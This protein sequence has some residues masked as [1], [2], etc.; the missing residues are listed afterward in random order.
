MSVRSSGCG[1]SI[2]NTGISFDVTAAGVTRVSRKNDAVATSA[3]DKSSQL[4]STSTA[5]FGTP[6]TRFKLMILNSELLR[7]QF[8]SRSTF[9]GLQSTPS[10]F[11]DPY[12]SNKWIQLYTRAGQLT[13]MS[14]SPA[15]QYRHHVVSF[16]TSY[17]FVFHRNDPHFIHFFPLFA[18]FLM[19]QLRTLQQVQ[20]SLAPGAFF[21]N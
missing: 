12:F 2:V 18:W 4:A 7:N 1:H 6:A 20:F 19:G 17:F 9:I 8:V 5:S 16:A 11:T 15:S 21:G 14:S 13:G 10:S 3:A